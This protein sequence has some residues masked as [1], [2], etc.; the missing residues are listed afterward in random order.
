M[1]LIW[2][3]ALQWLKKKNKRALYEALE[4][5][6]AGLESYILSTKFLCFGPRSRKLI[7]FMHLLFCRAYATGFP[8]V[9]ANSRARAHFGHL[10]IQ[11]CWGNLASM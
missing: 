5:I 6:K 2:V 9:A 1:N 3:F 8:I 11:V 7:T 4:K 10:H